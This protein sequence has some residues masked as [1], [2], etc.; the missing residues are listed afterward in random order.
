LST[1]YTTKITTVRPSSGRTVVIFKGSTRVDKLAT[2]T[3][4]Y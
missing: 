4:N 2:R 3:V 1:L